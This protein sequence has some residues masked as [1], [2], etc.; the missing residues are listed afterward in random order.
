MSQFWLIAA[1]LMCVAAFFVLWP[2]LR[3]S[4]KVED[5]SGDQEGFLLDL[6]NENRKELEEQL[7]AGEI[8]QAEF[9]QLSS[10]LEQGLLQDV[11]EQQANAVKGGRAPLLVFAVLVVIGAV[12]FYQQRGALPDVAVQ[13]LMAERYQQS[14]EAFQRG[15]EPDSAVTEELIAVLSERVNGVGDQSENRYL[16]AR[17]AAEHGR[18]GLAVEQYTTLLQGE[19]K[20]DPRLMAELAQVVFLASGNRI[21]P[22]VSLLVRKTLELNP[23]ET[24]ALGLAGIEAYEKAL[25]ETAIEY[26][27]TA[28]AA[29]PPGTPVIRGMEVGIE[30]A[31]AMLADSGVV[32]EGQL[33]TPVE[34]QIRLQLSLFRPL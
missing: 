8:T 6:F 27:Q 13:E 32:N 14:I 19:N 30:R 1:L 22:E 18:Y 29:M 23:Q 16:L 33:E 20:E 4:S 9:E 31:R 2:A 21:T 17:L 25:Y 10:E 7:Q 24:T 34:T 26:W 15:E 12:V 3:V 28:I 5:V 11:K